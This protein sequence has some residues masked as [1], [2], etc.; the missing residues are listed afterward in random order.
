MKLSPRLWYLPLTAAAIA[1]IFPLFWLVSTSLKQPG[2]EFTYPPEWIPSPIVWQNYVDAL[3]QQ[4]FGLY[5]RNTLTITVA[6]TLGSVITASLAAFGFARIRFPG[7]DFLFILLLSTMMLPDIVTL[8]PKYILF[9]RLHW[10]NTFLPLTIPFWFGGGAF[11]IFLIRQFF[12]TLPYELDEAARMDGASNFRIY[13]QLL[14]PL[15]VP[16]L[17]TVVILTAVNN[18]NDFLSPLIYLNSPSKF[19]LALGLQNYQTLYGTQWAWLM[20]ASMLMI[21]PM[22]ALFFSFQR[23]FIEGIQLTGLTGR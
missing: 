14:M 9:S 11:N 17:A 10:I 13:A 21:G 6:A 1:L 5:L 20:A 18:W 16:A 19:T 8:V 7:R 3:A 22:L 12:M 4:P 2:T 23:F 15:S